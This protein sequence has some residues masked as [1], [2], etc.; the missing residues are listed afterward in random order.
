MDVFEAIIRRRSIRQYDSRPVEQEKLE[1][2]LDAGRLAPSAKNAQAW[3]LFAVTDQA[4]I[5]GMG[6]AYMGQDFIAEAPVLLGVCTN[7]DRIMGNGVSARIVDGS[8]AMSFMVLEATEL[9]LGTCWLGKF[10]APAVKAA[11]N[12]PEEYT[13]VALTAM[14]YPDK[15][16][17]RRPRKAPEEVF[18]FNRWDDR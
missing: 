3:K 9:G 7:Q 2:I 13:V 18:R 5:R 12:I 16:Q 15:P 1:K 10:D 11:L 14:G 4:L 17:P 6:D 8:I